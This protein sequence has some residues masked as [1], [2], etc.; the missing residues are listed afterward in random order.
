[1]Y[2]EPRTP[3]PSGQ[4]VLLLVV[5]FLAGGLLWLRSLASPPK[6]ERFLVPRIGGRG[7]TPRAARRGRGASGRK[8]AAHDRGNVLRRRLSGWASSC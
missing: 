2:V 3:R 1:M 5:L 7:G 8:L 6:T 4:L